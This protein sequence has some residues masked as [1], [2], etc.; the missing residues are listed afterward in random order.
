VE[1][2]RRRENRGWEMGFAR[3]REVRKWEKLCNIVQFFAIEK[4]QRGRNQD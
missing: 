1:G 3:W 4:E 2:D